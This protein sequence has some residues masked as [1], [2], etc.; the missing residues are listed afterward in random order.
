MFCLAAFAGGN[1]R[2]F[3][4][5]KAAAEQCR[6]K[7]AKLE[8]FPEKRTAGQTQ[9]TKFSE[10]EINSYLALDL[11]SQYHPCL[12]SLVMK[13]EENRLKATATIDFDRLGK[14]S[15][16]MLPKLINLLFSGVH[17]LAADGQLVAKDGKAY[18]KLD[19]ALFDGSDLP[20]PLVEAIISAV[21]RKQNPPFD[22]LK[23]SE[24]P[25]EINKVDVSSGYIIV[26]Q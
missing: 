10:N 22:P 26:F 3:T 16:K 15:T 1:G 19:E 25:Y 5:S 13:F 17:T 8:A 12:K 4:P 24:M 21:G 9:T 14:S 18:F 23:P 7:L 20:K 2:L 11:S 6:L